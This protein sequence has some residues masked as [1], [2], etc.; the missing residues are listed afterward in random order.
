M[1]FLDHLQ[2]Y[3][4]VEKYYNDYCQTG[5]KKVFCRFSNLIFGT[6]IVEQLTITDILPIAR[7][8]LS[9]IS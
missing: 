4:D 1:D 6:G 5:T 8:D 3:M 9:F 7:T 2:D